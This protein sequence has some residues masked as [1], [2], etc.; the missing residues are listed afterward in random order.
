MQLSTET[1][2]TVLPDGLGPSQLLTEDGKTH[3]SFFIFGAQK[4]VKLEISPFGIDY[5]EASLAIPA[6]TFDNGNTLYSYWVKLYCT[7]SF[8]TD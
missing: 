6:L 5:L 4:D 8:A 3:L 7:S 2:T 1:I